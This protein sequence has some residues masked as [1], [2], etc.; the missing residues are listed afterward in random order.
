M[1]G[2]YRTYLA[3]VVF[4]HHILNIPIIGHY[5]VHGFFILSGYLMTC[6]ITTKYCEIDKGFYKFWLNRFLRLYPSYFVIFF[7]S[8]G[9]IAYVGESFS[10]SF[11]HII[12]LPDTSLQWFQNLT[13]LYLSPFPTSELPRISPPT[14]ALTV[15]LFFYLAISLGTSKTLQRSLVWLIVSLAYIITS[16]ILELPYDFRYSFLLAGTLPFSI[17]ATLYHLTNI[18]KYKNYSSNVRLVAIVFVIMNIIMLLSAYN[19][20]YVKIQFL[21]ELFFYGNYVIQTVFILLLS[22]FRLNNFLKKDS[23]VGALSYPI[24]LMHWQVSMLVSFTIFN[25]GELGFNYKGLTVF[26]VSLLLTILLSNL[27]VKLVEEPVEKLRI[28]FKN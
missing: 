20:K 26:C 10:T 14:W 25:S 16:Y 7:L 27:I 17:G 12:Y 22:K 2:T 6:I 13:L 19:T 11:R 23:K 24:Y 9:A 1:F 5:A 28:R 3:L 18:E 8:I 21:S 4:A 15:E